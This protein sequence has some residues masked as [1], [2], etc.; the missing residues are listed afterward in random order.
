MAR[1]N[2]LNDYLTDVAN[3]IRSKTRKRGQIEVKNFDTEIDSIPTDFY[4]NSVIDRFK[5]AQGENDIEVGDFVQYINEAKYIKPV[6]KYTGWGETTNSYNGEK[7]STYPTA[8]K[9]IVLEKNKFLLVYA[10]STDST[11]LGN[12]SIG[13]IRGG[14]IR[15][16][17]IDGNKNIVL[18]NKTFIFDTTS[19]TYKNFSWT[20]TSNT[21]ELLKINNHKVVLIYLG[22]NSINDNTEYHL[23]SLNINIDYDNN[24]TVEKP[25]ILFE[26]ITTSTTLSRF[27]IKS[28]PISTHKFFIVRREFSGNKLKGFILNFDIE[29]D[30]VSCSIQYQ[31]PTE[32]RYPYLINYFYRNN[33]IY[34]MTSEE[35]NN[36]N[37]VRFIEYDM[38]SN[39]PNIVSNQLLTSFS[40]G[41]EIRTDTSEYREILYRNNKIIFLS[42]VVQEGK[43]EQC[44]VIL[45]INDNDIIELENIIKLSDTIL[46][47]MC[48]YVLD[49]E[50]FLVR[51]QN[52][53]SDSFSYDFLS[54]VVDIDNDFN[55]NIGNPVITNSKGLTEDVAL[56]KCLCM[57][58]NNGY[59]ITI[60]NCY[61]LNEESKVF[62]GL[63]INNTHTVG[64]L[65]NAS[66]KI[67][68]IAHEY[69]KALEEIDVHR[70]LIND[71]KITNNILTEKG[72]NL[73]TENNENII[74]EGGS[75]GK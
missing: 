74:L 21:F 75:N 9:S 71:I 10:T 33:K 41:Y 4:I 32:N 14:R 29:N 24:V 7:L 58:F 60:E 34:L 65:K 66:D 51:Y 16:G 52:Y 49:D 62:L 59:Y 18:D 22:K 46:N 11:S 12:S 43:S 61:I 31:I 13:T 40:I 36:S 56:E 39:E 1:I 37:R 54:I 47:Y 3:A 53:R 26:R 67:F 27:R 5:I 17:Y 19:N 23:C 6:K 73:M 57:C 55:V 64:H 2:S 28:I 25:S 15:L 50:T 45:S 72:E 68:G 35:D 42:T 63:G 20:T 8:L 30:S 44:V 38:S 48:A 70:P 69:G